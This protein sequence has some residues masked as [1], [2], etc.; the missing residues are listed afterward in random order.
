MGIF[1]KK[2][3]E[4]KE[5]E[6]PKKKFR[7]A[8][9][10]KVLIIIIF[11][12]LIFVSINFYKLFKG[13]TIKT[14]EVVTGEI[15]NVD[16][17]KG[18]IY[19]DEDVATSKTDG[20]INFYVTNAERVY[21]GSF[22]YTINDTPSI[23]NNY[24]LTEN[25]I[26]K[27]DDR[28][29][30]FVNQVTDSDFYN[31]YA[32]KKSIDNMINEINIVKE[33]ENI[34]VEKEIDAKEKGYAKY[35]GLV[36][37]LIDG[38][39]KS[40]IDDFNDSLIKNYDNVTIG[41]QKK[42]VEAGASIY[43]IMKSP[44]FSIAFDSDYDYDNYNKSSNVTIKFINENVTTKG[45]VTSFIGNDGKKHFKLG[46]LDYP[47]KFL[48]KRVVDF[49][50]ENRKISGY[51]VPIKA[52]VSRNCYI[53]PKSLVDVDLE[54]NDYILYKIGKDGAKEKTI[55]NIAKEDN[56]FYYLLADDN[57][58]KLGYGEVITNKYNDTYSLSEVKKINGVYNANRGYAIFKNVDIIDKTNE[59]AIVKKGTVNS[60]SLYDRIVLDASFVDEGDLLQ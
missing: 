7:I 38:F 43:K 40:S 56:K 10:F 15:V 49:E 39:E 32:A 58:S 19:R 37:F 53:V 35:A 31:V 11:V 48:E 18:F 60:I 41:V 24:A 54:T 12:V 29:S 23:I 3:V 4:V 30:I 47:E 50:I 44:E 36:S 59:Y 42:E 25:D 2:K 45:H 52:I 21:R 14:F 51:K 6:K 26:K 17:H 20:Y 46:V 13:T 8:Y 16:R 33:L 57:M 28:I 27:I 55:V 1:K 34:D 9:I 5:I 22:I